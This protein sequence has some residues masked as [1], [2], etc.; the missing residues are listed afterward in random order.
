MSSAKVIF[1]NDLKQY[2]SM[3]NVEVISFDK[4]DDYYEIKWSDDS[5]TTAE[6]YSDIMT[7]AS[8][9]F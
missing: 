7:Q 3:E 8:K 4:A 9:I 1:D 5:E 2:D 6:Q